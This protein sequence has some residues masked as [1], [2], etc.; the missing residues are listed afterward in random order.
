MF[1]GGDGVAA[2]GVHD[3]DALLAGGLAVDIVDAGAGAA[4]NFEVVGGL[5]QVGVC[6]GGRSDNQSVILFDDGFDF[7]CAEAGFN[8]DI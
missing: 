7:I 1:T 4:D 2:G 8:V 6:L 3:H 5:N